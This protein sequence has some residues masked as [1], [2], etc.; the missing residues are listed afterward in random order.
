MTNR[1]KILHELLQRSGLSKTNY[2]K[3]HGIKDTPRL[4]QW[5][6]GNRNIKFSTL[7][8]FAQNDGL[9]IE[10]TYKIKEK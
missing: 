1:Q 8:Q 10:L 9:E 4:S 3:K 2:C 6:S 5:F 7:Q